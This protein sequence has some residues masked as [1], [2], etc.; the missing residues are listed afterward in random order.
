MSRGI[1]K[2][3]LIGNVGKDPELKEFGDNKSVVNI[4][5]ATSENWKDKDGNPQDRT[6]WHRVVAYNR[7]NYKLANIIN[8]YVTKGSKI[9]IEGSL[10][11]R[12]WEDNDGNDRYS[13]E[14]IASDMQMLGSKS[15]NPGQSPPAQKSARKASKPSQVTLEDFDDAIPF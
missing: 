1:N 10:Q 3:I 15:D 5:V 9:Y 12:K 8:E 4:T 6:E 14:V 13:T 7:G 11:T 2:V